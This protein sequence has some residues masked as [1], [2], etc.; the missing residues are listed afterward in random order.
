[1]DSI[2]NEEGRMDIDRVWERIKKGL[3]DGAAMSMD[4]IEE[5]TKIGKLKIEEMA[6]KKKIER[7]QIDAGERVFELIDSGKGKDIEGDLTVKKAV[8]NIRN[9]QAELIEI[10]KKIKAASQEAKAKRSN[11]GDDDDEVTGI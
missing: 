4:K 11:D 10:D 2:F 7:N 6:A 1:M 8:D 5:Y 3:R 9:L